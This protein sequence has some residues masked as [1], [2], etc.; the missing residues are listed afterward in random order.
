MTDTTTATR[1]R[2]V[3]RKRGPLDVLIDRT[4]PW[5]NPFSARPSTLAR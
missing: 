2:V 5:G 1:T 4:T 3:H